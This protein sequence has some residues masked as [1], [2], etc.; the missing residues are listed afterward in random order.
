MITD[1]DQPIETL[2]GVGPSLQGKLARL[3]IFRTTDLLLHLPMRYQDR[4]RLVPLREVRAQTECLVVGQVVESKITYG[5]R[6]SWLV[7]IEDDS[8][9]LGLRFF[10]FSRQQ[11]A[12]LRSGMFVRAFGEV[13]FGA[14]GLE[15]THPE[16][17]GYHSLPPETERELTPVYHTTKG[18]GQAR[19]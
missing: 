1:P 4:T 16:Y 7:T 9:F 10:Y 14:G 11:Q 13:R 8:G 5:R 12:S 3:G 6:R 18:L 19:I 15:M 17:R 2:K